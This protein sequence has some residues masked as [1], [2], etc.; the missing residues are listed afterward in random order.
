M[1]DLELIKLLMAVMEKGTRVSYQ[2]N[3]VYTFKDNPARFKIHL[4]AMEKTLKELNQAFNDVKDYI[5][6]GE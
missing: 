1:N 2:S 4:D 3:N 6:G 5:K